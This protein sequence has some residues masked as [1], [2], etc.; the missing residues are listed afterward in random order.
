MV[1]VNQ[2]P[3]VQK[4]LGLDYEACKTLRADLVHVSI[5]GFGLEG[6]RSD[7]TCYDLIA[8]GYSGVMDL[9]GEPDGA[10]QKIGAPAADMWQ[11]PMPLLPPYRHFSIA[12]EPDMVTAS[13][14]RWSTAWRNS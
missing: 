2:R 7:W 4:K 3:Q 5:T 14:L 1:V 8:E 13:M 10:P 11:A 9:T 6:K 12:A